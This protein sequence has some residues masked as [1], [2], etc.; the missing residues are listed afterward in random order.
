[1]RKVRP[2]REAAVM[3]RFEYI[4]R[5]INIEGK[6]YLP[7]LYLARGGSRVCHSFGI[8]PHFTYNHPTLSATS[9]VSLTQHDFNLLKQTEDS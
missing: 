3:T 2:P 1:M 5:S 4:D 9:V 6:V 8:A 7:L